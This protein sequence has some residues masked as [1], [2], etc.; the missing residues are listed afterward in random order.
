MAATARVVYLAARMV[1]GSNETRCS[2]LTVV[3]C[4][5]SARCSNMRCLLKAVAGLLL[6]LIENNVIVDSR[7]D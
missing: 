2:V 3:M 1:D 5:P 6:M 4:W 7:L